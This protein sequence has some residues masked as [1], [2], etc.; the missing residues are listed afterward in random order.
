MLKLD[1]S[2]LTLKLYIFDHFK[3]FPRFLTFIHLILHFICHHRAGQS[4]GHNSQSYSPLRLP[5]CCSAN[6]ERSPRARCRGG[7]R[8]GWGRS[9]ADGRARWCWIGTRGPQRFG[10]IDRRFHREHDFHVLCVGPAGLHRRP[11]TRR[12]DWRLCGSTR[13]Q[14]F[15][16]I[17]SRTR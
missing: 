3:D 7:K 9:F 15:W 13:S 14:R 5:S 4:L 16:N 10:P 1:F 12:R 6:L 2:Y 8:H 11:V 17:R